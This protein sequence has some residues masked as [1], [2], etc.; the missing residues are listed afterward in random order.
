MTMI[1]DQLNA[2]M[3]RTRVKNE[4]FQTPQLVDEYIGVCTTFITIYMLVVLEEPMKR[5][6]P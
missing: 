5:E 4:Q 6:S 2:T 1:Y 3:L